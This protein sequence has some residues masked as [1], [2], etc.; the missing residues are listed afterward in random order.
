MI[1][2]DPF[3]PVFDLDL[4][5]LSDR[6]D[7]VIR[8][9]PDLSTPPIAALSG[10]RSEDEFRSPLIV[11]RSGGQGGPMKVWEVPEGYDIRKYKVDNRVVPK[12][13]GTKDYYC[14]VILPKI[15]EPNIH[16]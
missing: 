3:D 11:I 15:Q 1:Q 13:D 10:Y 8:L 7:L 5:Y 16:D 6:L 2:I 14:T 9:K 12:N 4:Q